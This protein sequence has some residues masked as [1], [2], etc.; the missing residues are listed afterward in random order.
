MSQGVAEKR[1]VAQGQARAEA[2]VHAAARKAAVD[3][4]AAEAKVVN[5]LL[6]VLLLTCVSLSLEDVQLPV[7]RVCN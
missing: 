6:F 3:K 5:C 7:S 4:A 1:A 2:T